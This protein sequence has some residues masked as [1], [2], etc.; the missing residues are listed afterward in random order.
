MGLST[1]IRRNVQPISAATVA[2]EGNEICL[3]SGLDSLSLDFP[4]GAFLAR[5]FSLHTLLSVTHANTFLSLGNCCCFARCSE[6][7]FLEAE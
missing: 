5:R 2:G 3:F 7:D 6:A 1:N 4:K